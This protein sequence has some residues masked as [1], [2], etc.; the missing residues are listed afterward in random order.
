MTYFLRNALWL[1]VG[2]FRWKIDQSQKSLLLCQWSWRENQVFHSF[3]LFISVYCSLQV[4]EVIMFG[5]KALELIKELQR[6]K[7]ATLPP[8]NVSLLGAYPSFLQHTCSAHDTLTVTSQSHTQC[9]WHD[10]T[11][12]W[13][14]M[15]KQSQA[16]FYW[17][18]RIT[19]RGTPDR[20]SLLRVR[21]ICARS[22][23]APV[24]NGEL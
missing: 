2:S 19:R 5:E 8:F 6:C 9:T 13:Q 22:Q 12:Q 24:Q 15:N 10:D 18:G 21:G 20:L 23:N 11:V 17:R 14:L 3:S 7:N 1:A 4:A 16:G